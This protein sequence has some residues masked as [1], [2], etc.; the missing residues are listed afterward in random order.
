MNTA[1]SH[2]RHAFAGTRWSTITQV[3]DTG[4]RSGALAELC[5]RYRYPVYAYL[6]RSGHVPAIAM[7]IAQSFLGHVQRHFGERSAPTSRQ[8]RQF[9][10]AHLQDYLTR[11]WRETSDEEADECESPAELEARYARDEPNAASP[12]QAFQHGFALEILRHAAERLR[13]EARQTGHGDMYDAL[14][15]FLARDP[16]PGQYEE[17]AHA[18]RTRPLAVVLALKRLRQRLREI[19]SDELADT[20]ASADELV[21]EQTA[22]FAAL[23]RQ[24]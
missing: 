5:A 8:F 16:L 9:L 15:P 11:D 6:R 13:N 21:A 10:L 23:Q 14:T 20:V 4:R 3:F 18:L 12:E 7:D 2:D 17:L 24:G 1:S 22:M 19:A